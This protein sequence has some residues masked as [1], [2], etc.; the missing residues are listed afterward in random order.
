MRRP[1]RVPFRHSFSPMTIPSVLSAPLLR[2][3][4]VLLLLAGALVVTACDSLQASDASTPLDA[5]AAESGTLGALITTT[6]S[7]LDLTGAQAAQMETLAARFEGPPDPGAL[8]TAAAEMHATL[9]DAQVD[10]LADRLRTAAERLAERRANADRPRG[11]RLQ[12][13]QRPTGLLDSLDL[14]DDQTEA[15]RSL[16]ADYRTQYA[17]LVAQHDAGA[18]PS[19]VAAAYVELATALRSDAADILTDEQQAQIDARRDARSE[20]REAMHDARNAALALTAL[21]ADGFN[22]MRHLEG[23]GPALLRDVDTWFAAREALLTDTQAEITVVHASLVAQHVRQRF[24]Q[25]RPGGGGFGRPG[26]FG[27]SNR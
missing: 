10:S 27:G 4:G 8:W 6:T 9:T 22:A 3:V 5:P 23:R 13:P 24:Q 14:S 19:D 17:D 20:R 11:P 18:D 7:T 1:V 12:R 15:L 26:G 2:G 21:Q 25:R 16:R